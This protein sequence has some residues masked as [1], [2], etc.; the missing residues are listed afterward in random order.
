MK[1][2]LSSLFLTLAA[3]GCGA[4]NNGGGGTPTPTPT[5]GMTIADIQQ[6]N[7]A[8]NTSVTLEGIVVTAVK[9]F[10]NNTDFWGQ[11]AGGG[12][13]SGIYFF[14][15]DAVVPPQLA[16]G[17]EVTVSGTYLEYQGP[18]SAPW[19][20][21]ISEIR[22]SDVTITNSGLTPTASVVAA[23]ELG[24][25]LTGNAS[26]P[27][28]FVLVEIGGDTT[29]I[30]AALGFGEF[31][32]GNG[33]AGEQIRVDDQIF[34][35]AEV[36]RYNTETITHLA[37]I[38]SYSF[39]EYKLEP[40]DV[41]DLV[42]TSGGIAAATV[43]MVQDTAAGGHPQVGQF[44]S[45]NDVVVTA[46]RTA[47]GETSVWVRDAGTPA[48]Y[49]GLYVFN[50]NA[51]NTVVPA[52]LTTGNVIDVVGR[53][54]EY[55][56]LT[57]LV[58][59]TTQQNMSFTIVDPT[60]VDVAPLMVSLATL[61]AN[62]EQYEGQLI[63]LTDATLTQSTNPNANGEF[64]ITDGTNTVQVDD[65]VFPA[66]DTGSSTANTYT[67]VRGVFGYSFSQYEILPRS[68]LDLTRQ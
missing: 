39:D 49:S 26:E 33:Q 44:V 56:N 53:L 12:Q 34:A 65:F 43:V 22:V 14:D 68:A 55:F 25:A 57:E 10:N 29:V 63:Q 23:T 61:V 62:P 17:D 54:D 59:D 66:A 16:V 18:T 11:D 20:E 5:P 24:E 19:I 52:T 21:T 58:L 4:T 3:A 60:P 47:N 37:G 9:P 64:N 46:K 50:Q 67:L 28:E 15:G 13:Y 51:G 38:W 31:M 27:Y 36:G 6:G 30:N 42:G 48:I 1:K 7:V 41:S 40:R 35:D 8:V 45:L 32:V 2:L